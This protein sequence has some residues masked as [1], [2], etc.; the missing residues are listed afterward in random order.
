[1]QRAFSNI[2]QSMDMIASYKNQALSNMQ[3]TVNA[4]STE[5]QKAQTYLDRVRTEQASEAVA[6]IDLEQ[7]DEIRI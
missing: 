2:Y 3:Q 7:S 5:V 6:D 1:L 4:L